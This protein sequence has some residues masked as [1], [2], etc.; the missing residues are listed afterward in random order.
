MV[1]WMSFPCISLRGKAEVSGTCEQNLAVQFALS[2]RSWSIKG[3]PFPP[4]PCINMPIVRTPA[5]TFSGGFWGF[6]IFKHSLKEPGRCP[7]MRGDKRGK[8]EQFPYEAGRKRNQRHPLHG[9][10]FL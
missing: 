6:C 7:T 3:M 8:T 2:C 10:F 1:K 5:G 4:V 9:V